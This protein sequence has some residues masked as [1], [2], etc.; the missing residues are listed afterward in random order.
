MES[1]FNSR[2]DRMDARLDQVERT[3]TTSAKRQPAPATV[4]DSSSRELYCSR[5]RRN[6]H[7]AETCHAKRDKYGKWLN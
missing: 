7:T 3:Q 1:R 6:T 2:L 4:T 5:C